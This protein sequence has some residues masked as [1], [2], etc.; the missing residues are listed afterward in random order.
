MQRV[1]ILLLLALICGCRPAE[2]PAATGPK[3]L[4]IVTTTAMVADLAQHVAGEHATV[5]SLMGPGIDPHLFRATFQDI[6]RMK[7]ADVLLYSGLKLEG[8][9]QT[10]L[11]GVR[12]QQTITVAAITDQIP[13]E[14]LR[15][16][17]PDFSH[18]DPHVWHDVALWAG[19]LDRVAEVLSQKDAAHADEYRTNAASYKAEL[20]KLDAWTRERIATIPV[21]TRFLVTAHDAFAYFSRTYGIEERS[22]QG[23][24]TESE[25]GIADINALIDFLVR[26]EVPALFMEATV[27]RAALEAVTE[28]ARKRGWNVREGGVL[29]S[30]SMGRPGSYEGTY[31]GMI[32]H[33]VTTIVRALGGE[34]PE[35]GYQGQLQTGAEPA[36]MP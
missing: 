27:N 28:G 14:N 24:S 2:Q 34:A 13:N 18:P 19:C 33:N 15:S 26:Q 3:K 29:Y 21:K 25:A 31:I 16:P 5:T 9:M 20:L 12:K 32:D 8:A 22:A 17:D 1:W 7:R 6:D 4:N 30:D 23:I 10:A 11:E 36:K 35:K